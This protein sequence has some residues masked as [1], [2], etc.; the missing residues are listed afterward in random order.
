MSIQNPLAAGIYGALSGSTALT[1]L[2]TGGTA[3]KAVYQELAPEGGTATPYVVYNFQ[4][5]STPQWTFGE[6]AFENVVVQAKAI[7]SGPSMLL[8]GS[9]AARIDQALAGT[10]TVAGYKTMLCRRLQDVSYT[11]LVSG[12]RFQHQGGLYRL[13]A[14]NS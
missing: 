6:V 13:Q 7:T 11:E 10:V 4:S 2:L 9:I 3:T 5:P 12:V 14:T 8:G 1:S